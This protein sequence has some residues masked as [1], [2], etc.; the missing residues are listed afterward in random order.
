MAGQRDQDVYVVSAD[1]AI[2]GMP[3]GQC[4]EPFQVGDETTSQSNLEAAL[5]SN[6][7]AVREAVVPLHTRCLPTTG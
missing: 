2:F 7:D 3:C 5:E 4:G 6:P 1:S